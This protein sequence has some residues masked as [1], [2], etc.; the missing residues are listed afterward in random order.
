MKRHL[1]ALV[2]GLVAASASAQ[3]TLMS[4]P[5]LSS[6]MLMCTT[7]GCWIDADRQRDK[8][9]NEPYL[10][11]GG[12]GTSHA[13]D[14]TDASILALGLS[15]NDTCWEL[16]ANT[17]YVCEPTAGTCDTAGEMLG[18]SGGSGA[19]ISAAYAVI[20]LD[21]TLS[22]E[23]RIIAAV[24]EGLTTNDAGANGDFSFRL[25][26]LSA[27][28][29]TI[30]VGNSAS[31][32]EVLFHNN[33]SAG[34]TIA[35]ERVTGEVQRT[36][37]HENP[38]NGNDYHGFRAPDSIATSLEVELSAAFLT[39]LATPDSA[40][41]RAWLSDE[42]GTGAAVFRA[43]NSLNAT[44][45]ADALD[46][47]GE[48]SFEIPNSASPSVTVFGQMAGDNDFWA[49]SRGALIWYDGTAATALVGVLASDT[50]SNGQVPVWNTGGT[51]TWETVS[52]GG[53]LGDPGSNGL[54]SRTALNTTVAR[55][56]VG[57]TGEIA[58]TNC[59]GVSGNPTL[60]VPDHERTE[61]IDAW[62]VD[63]D[64]TQCTLGT[65]SV[66]INSGPRIADLQC[67]DN[68]AGEIH[69]RYRMPQNWGGGSDSTDDLVLSIESVNTAAS[70]SGVLAFDVSYQCRGDSG[71]MNSTWSTAG[72]LDTTYDTQN[73]NEFAEL[74]LDP[75]TCAAGDMVYGRLVVDA[76]TTTVTTPE[77]NV[78]IIGFR[79]GFTL[80]SLD[81]L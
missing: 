61:P 58:C 36:R 44:D 65:A 46:L 24:D 14:C 9:A 12:Y 51:V 33:G 47:G 53:G 23:R 75:G 49:A 78:Q 19:P 13:T 57:T 4:S 7:E 67:A 54:V 52:G 41:F 79:F 70:P 26:T 3:T 8:D 32:I 15:Q 63:P 31:P 62:A 71:S 28:T 39:F 66:Q 30:V 55:S 5:F 34:V 45:L 25:G 68:A 69:F 29:R 43:S 37:F 16:D 20:A 1:L 56:L 76:T 42:T 48:T 38:A 11:G 59:D 17:L 35:T 18:I 77:T 22:A 27:G 60:S 80:T 81:N 72:A 40:N 2:V 73:D 74:T 6:G 50:P 64:G 10:F 21:G